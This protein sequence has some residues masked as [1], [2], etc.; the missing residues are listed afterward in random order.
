MIDRYSRAELRALW[1]DQRRFDTW[2]EVE[3]A[4]CKAMEAEGSVPAGTADRASSIRRA[5]S[6]SRRRRA[7]T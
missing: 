3:L 1:S 4:A 7:T 2:L 5:S 6:R